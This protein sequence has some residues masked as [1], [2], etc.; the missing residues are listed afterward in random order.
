M[1][2]EKLHVNIVS[3]VAGRALARIVRWRKSGIA[4]TPRRRP[5][6]RQAVEQLAGV[7]LDPSAF[8]DGVSRVPEADVRA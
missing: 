7:G 3:L 8:V 2:D 1:P 4:T 5:S 6:R